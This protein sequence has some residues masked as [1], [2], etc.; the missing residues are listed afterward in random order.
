MPAVIFILVLLVTFVIGFVM[1][2]VGAHIVVTNLNDI[3][4]QGPS[5]WPVFW[6]LLVLVV[7]TGGSARL[8]K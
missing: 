4:T 1:L 5:F 3:L 7:L 6:I 2:G 8:S